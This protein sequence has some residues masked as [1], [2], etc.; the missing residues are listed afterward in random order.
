MAYVQQKEKGAFVL[1]AF[2]GI[3][4]YD[5]AS[6]Q[7]QR[8]LEYEGGI[9][10]FMGASFA[11]EDLRAFQDLVRKDFALKLYAGSP[12]LA[13]KMLRPQDR[14]VANELHPE[15]LIDLRTNLKDIRNAAVTHLDAYESIR[16]HVPPKERRGIILIDPPF[17]KKEEFQLLVQQMAEW[18]KRWETGCYILWYPIKANALTQIDDLYAEAAAL[19]INRTW[20]SEFMIRDRETPEG[21]NGCGLLIFNTPF[22]IPERVEAVTPELTHALGGSVRSF[23][24]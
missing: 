10:A 20:V 22:Q 23:Y 24:L 4:L 11:N 8:T 12:V 1:D 14:L 5:L 15:D 21:L 19:K 6:D 9:G 7:A 2:A 18:K 13:A 17:E 16:G 3:G